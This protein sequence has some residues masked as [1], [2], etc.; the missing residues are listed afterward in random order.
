M[1][2]MYGYIGDVGGRGLMAGVEIVGDRETKA[3]AME[4]GKSLNAK[5]MELGL[6]ATIFSGCIRIAPLTITV[7]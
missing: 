6:S 5:L 4:F 3:P 2:A 7:S 1:S